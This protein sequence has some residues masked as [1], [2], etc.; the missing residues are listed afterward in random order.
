[1]K[2]RSAASEIQLTFCSTHVHRANQLAKSVEVSWNL[3]LSSP[4]L[5]LQ[6]WI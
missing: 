6:T 3:A 5:P 1:M 4:L 2:L